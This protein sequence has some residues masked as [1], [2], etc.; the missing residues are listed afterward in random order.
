MSDGHGDTASSTLTVTVN[1]NPEAI[2]ARADTASTS[3]DAAAATGNVLANDSSASPDD[4]STLFVTTTGPLT[5]TGLG[6]TL[7]LNADGSY[8]YNSASIPG[9]ETLALGS[10]TDTFNYTVSD[11]HGDT[12]SS[13]L[14]VTVNINP[15]AITARAD[16]ASTSDDAAAAT[17]NVLANDSSASPDDQ[18]TLFVTT[19][20]SA[21]RDRAGRH[22]DAQ[23][24][25]QLQ[26]QLGDIPGLETLALGS[27][28]DT[29]NY[30]VSDG[31]GDTAS[32]TLTVTVNIN[33]EAITARADGIDQRRRGCGD[34]QCSGERQQRQPR[35]SIDAVCDD[36]RSADRDGLAAR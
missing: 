28:T 21:D 23:C 29:F 32:S 8:S 5:G 11:G 4:Q 25:R 1:I 13:T 18:S 3:D 30:T 7:T 33:P 31:H 20:G 27:Y 12:A 36:D 14:T 15:E 17:G 16:T 6:G 24:R 34:G 22:A 26:L 2:T 10:Y 35:R 9:L 19:T